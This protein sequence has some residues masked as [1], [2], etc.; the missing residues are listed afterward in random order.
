[1]KFLQAFAQ[2]RQESVRG[3]YC[4]SCNK[5]FRLECSHEI[6]NEDVHGLKRERLTTNPE[7]HE[8]QT[9]ENAKDGCK[10]K[11]F[12]F[13]TSRTVCVTRKCPCWFNSLPELWKHIDS[14]SCVF[15]FDSKLFRRIFD[16]KDVEEKSQTFFDRESNSLRCP[17]CSDNG[18]G[19]LEFE[20]MSGLIEHAQSDDCTLEPDSDIMHNLYRETLYRIVDEKLF[21]KCVQISERERVKRD[22]A[23]VQNIPID[24]GAPY[25]CRDCEKTYPK[26]SALDCHV[27]YKHKNRAPC[28]PQADWNSSEC[29]GRKCVGEYLGCDEVFHSNFEQWIHIDTNG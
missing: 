11:A 8:Q 18:A 9:L 29:P 23:A 10:T 17:N 1:M 28:I 2:A 20:T 26:E 15:K 5:T 7:S 6:H 14:D 3:P 24:P 16:H 27:K 25:V 21:K 22:E 12:K 19:S 4:A 13:R